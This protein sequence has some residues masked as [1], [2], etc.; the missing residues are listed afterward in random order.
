M[1]RIVLL[2][3]AGVWLL[4]GL[5]I[6]CAPQIFYRETPGL[7]L[8]GP[9]NVHFIRDVAL[10]FLASA[11]AAAWGAWRRARAAALAGV[12]WPLLHALFHMQIWAHRGFPLD[13][14]LAFDLAAVIAPACIAAWAAMTLGTAAEHKA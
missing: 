1:S 5:Y 14:I 12:A 4:T 6:F 10:A 3:V 2:A 13:G 11:G 8:M 9:F 7:S